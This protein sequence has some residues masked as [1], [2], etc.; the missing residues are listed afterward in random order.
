VPNLWIYQDRFDVDSF[1]IELL[2]KEIVLK[3]GQVR[4]QYFLLS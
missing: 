4:A 3:F 1:D 2:A